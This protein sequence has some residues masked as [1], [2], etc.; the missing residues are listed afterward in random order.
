MTFTAVPRYQPEKLPL[1]RTLKFSMQEK[2]S[3]MYE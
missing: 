3:E 1:S 2:V